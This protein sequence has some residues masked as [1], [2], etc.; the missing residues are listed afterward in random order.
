MKRFPLKQLTF[1]TIIID[2]YISDWA[3]VKYEVD[4]K[5]F[6]KFIVIPKFE[7]TEIPKISFRVFG[8]KVGV[9]N[10]GLSYLPKILDQDH[11]DTNLTNWKIKFAH[12]R[13]PFWVYNKDSSPMLYVQ[14][15][16]DAEEY[17]KCDRKYLLYDSKTYTFCIEAYM[18]NAY[19]NVD[20]MPR[21]VEDR[22]YH[23]H[24]FDIIHLGDN[25]F[26]VITN[27]I[28]DA[29]NNSKGIFGSIEDKLD[30]L[31]EKF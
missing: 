27:P 14:R 5:S 4:H 23:D 17:K 8:G 30:Q 1:K 7:V 26:D 31:I 10:C 11:D 16:W 12:G 9:L 19:S 15:F 6:Q 18:V 22:D 25:I 21:E 2:P 28:N 29:L 20:G 13:Y 24:L 3:T